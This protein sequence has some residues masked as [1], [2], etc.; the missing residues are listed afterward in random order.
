M[1][2]ENDNKQ[3][4]TFKNILSEICKE[5]SIKLTYLSKDWIVVLEKD[6]KCKILAGYK[7]DLNEHG[8][9][10]VCDDK[11]ALCELLEHYHLPVVEHHIVYAPTN[12]ENYAIGCNNINY[13]KELFIKY[14]AS[15]VLK[16]NNGTCGNNVYHITNEK[17][18]E[19]YYLK[20]SKRSYS[21]SLCPFID[22]ENEY[23]V[24]IFQH[25][26]ELIYKKEL[27]KV[28][29]DDVSS[30]KELLRNF[31]YEYFKDYD[32]VNKDIIL[33]E[34]E[35]YIYN[36]KFNL[37]GGAKASFDIEKE[38][39]TEILKLATKV[40]NTIDLKFGSIDIIR[41]KNGK[42][43]VLEINSG[44]MMDNLIKENE[45]GYEIAKS[46]YKKAIKAMFKI[47]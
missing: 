12:N 11:Y 14:N 24:I 38:I 10:E 13:L 25:N 23:R 7:F 4:K 34:N 40:A 31:N 29:G 47:K 33:K 21:L 41:D 9:G 5:Q 30:I 8:L 22:I 6:N 18:L 20:L 42:Y 3:E 15:V 17:D 37:S 43:Y 26:P 35:E 27:P 46:I 28:Y 16:I 36:W 44:V 45:N 19:Y 1:K 39:K 32:G 2:I